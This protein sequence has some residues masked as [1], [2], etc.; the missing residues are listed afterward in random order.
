MGGRNSKKIPSQNEQ[1]ITCS[2]KMKV[3]F[4]CRVDSIPHRKGWSSDVALPSYPKNTRREQRG[5]RKARLFSTGVLDTETREQ[6]IKKELQKHLFSDEE[7]DALV[8]DLAEP[9]DILEL[10]LKRE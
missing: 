4:D 2:V 3:L 9:L 6:Q 10:L 5:V 8:K 1:E 7:M